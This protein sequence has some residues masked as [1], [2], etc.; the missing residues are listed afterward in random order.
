MADEVYR[1]KDANGVVHYGDSKDAPAGSEKIIVKVSPGTP[2]QAMSG[3][4]PAVPGSAR[5][6]TSVCAVYARAMVDNPSRE[7]WVANANKIKATCPGVGFECITVYQH[8]EKNQ[9]VSF[10]LNGSSTFFRDTKR[11]FP[12]AD[13]TR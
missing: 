12:R 4:A 2:G 13:R 10:V 1:W 11:D 6:Q 3:T 9:C 5:D 8:P 7:D